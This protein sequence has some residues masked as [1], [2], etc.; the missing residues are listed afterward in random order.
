MTKTE[1][2]MNRF[3]IL[4]CCLSLFAVSFTS[5]SKDEESPEWS[6]LYGEWMPAGC[7]VYVDD[8]FDYS[9]AFLPESVTLDFAADGTLT[10][11]N[12]DS[13]AVQ[14][15]KEGKYKYTILDHSGRIE[16][17]MPDKV[18]SV[19]YSEDKKELYINVETGSVTNHFILKRHSDIN[20]S[21]L[22]FM[23]QDR[24][25]DIQK[26]NDI[27]SHFSDGWLKQYLLEQGESAAY[28]EGTDYSRT[29]RIHEFK[30]NDKVYYHL[31]YYGLSS[32]GDHYLSYDGKEADISSNLYD[33]FWYSTDWK[34]IYIFPKND[35]NRRRNE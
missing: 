17:Q 12:S 8:V 19:G 24:N 14:F 10:I 21:E 26:V 9:E 32:Y 20:I 23:R 7:Y 30:L 15:L 16:I 6:F 18:Y 22:P 5:C 4:S 2:A 27:C 28:E 35:E 1:D 13:F 25:I 11:K 29:Y 34:L 33:I 3:L 31:F